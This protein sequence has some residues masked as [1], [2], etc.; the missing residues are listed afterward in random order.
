MNFQFIVVYL[1]QSIRKNAFFIIQK[2]LR[3]EIN[4]NDKYFSYLF[5]GYHS[6]KINILFKSIK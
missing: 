2:S 4:Y 1:K 3:K 6:T 5:Y